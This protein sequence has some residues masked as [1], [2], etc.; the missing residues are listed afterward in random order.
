MDAQLKLSSWIDFKLGTWLANKLTKFVES[1]TPPDLRMIDMAAAYEQAQCLYVAAKLK[2]ADSLAQGPK[3]ADTLARE[4]KVQADPLDRVLRYLHE[5]GVFEQDSAGRY[6]LSKVSEFLLSDHPQSQREFIILSGEEAY[7]AWG[8]LLHAVE[9]G[10]NAFAHTHGMRFFDYHHSHPE[11][12]QIFDRAMLSVSALPD[13]AV[14]ADY[15]FSPYHTVVDLGGGR[16]NLLRQITSR[17]PLVQGILFDTPFVLTEEFRAQWHQAGFSERIKLQ[18]GDFFESIPT[19]A[20]AYLVKDVIHNWPDDKVLQLYQN[21]HRH[22]QPEAKLL[23][24]EMVIAAGDPLRRV[25]LNLDVNMLIIHNG[26]ERTADQH[27]QL[28]TE[29]GFKLARIVPTRSILSV[30]EAEQA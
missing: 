15:D 6:T 16:G 4:L 18:A 7:A 17:Y 14:A 13:Q 10:G 1:R 28:L 27:R 23:V 8:N 22:M 21:I 30:I 3:D 24:A 26:R 5:L 11:Y 25:K 12:A 19:P 2:V 20:D 29:A 9:T